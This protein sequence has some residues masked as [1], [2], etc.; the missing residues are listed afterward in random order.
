MPRFFLKIFIFIAIA[1]SFAPL[2]VSAE[3]IIPD[4]EEEK[5][6]QLKVQILQLQIEILKAQIALLTGNAQVGSVAS[7]S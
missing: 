7:V 6:S 4:V 5:I 2:C 1:I 3:T